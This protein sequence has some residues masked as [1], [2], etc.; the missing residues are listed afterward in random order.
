MRNELHGHTEPGDTITSFSAS[1]DHLQVFFLFFVFS[2]V[3]RD[4]VVQFWQGGERDISMRC[5]FS[6]PL[7]ASAATCACGRAGAG[8][9]PSCVSF[10]WLQSAS[11]KCR[12]SSR[13][14]GI[15]YSRSYKVLDRLPRGWGAKT[16][17]IAC[18]PF[19]VRFHAYAYQTHHFSPSERSQVDRKVET[20]SVEYTTQPPPPPLQHNVGT[21]VV[22]RM[23]CNTISTQLKTKNVVICR[24]AALKGDM[25]TLIGNMYDSSIPRRSSLIAD[26]D[27]LWWS[28]CGFG[29]A[30]HPHSR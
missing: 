6:Q 17:C 13:E 10:S 18:A 11:R 4:E 28:C 23:R 16:T 26:G 3:R 20:R 9:K 7:Q 2:S 21:W 27:N 8:G 15:T 25:N 1:L 12:S 14:T 29:S 22:V 30:R 5:V 24:A 19:A